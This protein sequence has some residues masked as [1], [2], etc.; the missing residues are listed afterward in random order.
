M[1]RVLVALAFLAAATIAFAEEAPKR[2]SLTV[3]VRT[4]SDK[5][6]VR[7][8]LWDDPKGFPEDVL[9][10]T[11]T[12]VAAPKVEKHAATCVFEDVAAGTYAIAVLHDLNESNSLDK[13][14]LGIPKEPLGFSNG[15]RIRFR[16]PTFDEAKFEHDGTAKTLEISVH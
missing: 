2:G 10:D 3:K 16:A 11:V 8:A 4:K 5:G 13:N 9:A 12:R 15:V 7:C 14:R 6:I 1:T